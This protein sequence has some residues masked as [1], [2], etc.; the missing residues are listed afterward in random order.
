MHCSLMPHERPQAPQLAGS[1][2]R[3]VQAPLHEVSPGAQTE[4][5]LPA[6]QTWLP[7]QRMPQPPQFE[8]SLK[9]L[10][11]R[12]PQLVNPWFPSH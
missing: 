12:L 1:N 10:M 7:L 9:V 11:H 5:Q 6:L 3:S 4:T 8:G 2:C